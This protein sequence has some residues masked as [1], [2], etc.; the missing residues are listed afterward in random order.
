MTRQ[1][2]VSVRELAEHV[3]QLAYAFNVKLDVRQDMDPHKGTSMMFTIFDIKVQ[4]VII[5][6]VVNG[7]SYAIAVHELGHCISPL[8][9]IS[10]Y[11][12]QEFSGPYPLTLRAAQRSLTQELAAWEWAEHHALIW[13]PAMEKTKVFGLSTYHTALD[14]FKRAEEQRAEQDRKRPAGLRTWLKGLDLK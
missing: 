6:P 5:A 9:M 13:T 4:G 12:Q 11:L 8:G 3:E 1:Q 7:S 10:V 14:R 2:D